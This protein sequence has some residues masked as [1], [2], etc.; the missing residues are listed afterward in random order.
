MSSHRQALLLSLLSL[1]ITLALL[2]MLTGCQMPL[3]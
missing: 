1:A 3:R 2:F